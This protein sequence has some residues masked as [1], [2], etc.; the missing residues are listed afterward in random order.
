MKDEIRQI[1]VTCSLSDFKLVNEDFTRCRCSVFYTGKNRNYSDITEEAAK[2]FIERKGYANVPVVA[3][4]IETGNGK[5]KIGGHDVELEQSGNEIKL[6][7][8][9]VPFGLIPE[10]CNP[11]MEDITDEYGVTKKYFCCDLILWTHR[12]PIMEAAY[13]DKVYF[14]QSMEAVFH[15]VRRDGDYTVVDAF[16]ISALCLLNKSD[17][18]EDNVEPCFEES[19]VTALFSNNKLKSDFNELLARYKTFAKGG[20][21]TMENEKLITA[22]AS[23]TY[24]N[25][26]NETKQRYSFIQAIGDDKAAV[27]DRV[28]MCAYSVPFMENEEGNIVFDFDK[29]ETVKFAVSADGYDISGDLK[30]IAEAYTAKG[31]RD[32]SDKVKA[33]L[34]VY[35]KAKADRDAEFEKLKTEYKKTAAKLEKY[36]KADEALKIEKHKSD[37]DSTIQAYRADFEKHGISASFKLDTFANDPAIYSMTVDDLKAKLLFMLGEANHESGGGSITGLCSANYSLGSE[38]IEK[39]TNDQRGYT[40]WF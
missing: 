4:L 23:L 37:I 13:S 39:T 32:V 1:N 10:D 29:K 3:H 40:G 15:R 27:L 19:K 11:A 36:I 6:K 30:H 24:V 38:T 17:S 25:P 7:E 21:A 22:L 28:E 8:L 5:Y 26:A 18:K 34:E 9:T 31:E 2:L 12:Y 20:N 14:N 33:Q 16:S 35:E